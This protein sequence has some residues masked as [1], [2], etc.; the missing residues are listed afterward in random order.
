MSKRLQAVMSDDV[1]LESLTVEQLKSMLAE[2]NLP[3]TGKKAELIDRLNSAKQEN[4]IELSTSIW[5]RNVIGRF[6]LAQSVGSIAAVLLLMV[7]VLNPSILGFGEDEPVYQPI[8]FDADKTRW[9]AQELVN[10]GHPEWEGRM[11][12]SPEEAAAA[13]MI[14]D[15]LTE[16]GYS[17]QLNTYPVPM[18]AINSEPIVSMCIPPADGLFGAPVSGASCNSG[19]GAQVTSFNHRTDFVLQGYSGSADIQFGQEM[20]LIDL[21]DGTDDGLWGTA[22]GK[23][24]IVRGGNSIDGNTGIY[25]KAA[26][27]GLA[28]IFR[29]NNQS[30]CG[31]IENDDCVP[32][33]KSILVDDMKA[34]NSGS[35]PENIPF[36]A[37]SNNTG[38][39]MLEL[40]AQG[41]YLRLFSDVDNTGELSVSVPCGTLYG[42][43]DDL[44]IVGAHHDT[45]YHA[46]GAVD[47]TSGTATVLEMARQL[48]MIAN[49]SGTPDYTLRFCT[50][51]G[52]EEGLWGSKAYVGANANELAR[53]LRLYI[54]LDM[55]HVDVDIANRGNTL[56]FFSN[57]KEDINAMKDIVKV[58]EQERPDL[59]PKYAVTTGLLEGERG[60]PDGMPYNS[61][62]GPFVYDLP[63]GV[64]GNALVCYGTGSYE[65]HTYA[66]TMDRFNEESL[67]VSVIAYGTYIRHLAW[68]VTA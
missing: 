64:V 19:L 53:N 36:I 30:N 50:W 48:A 61:D 33:F 42:K 6:N 32:I 3:K 35:I 25:I 39:Q 5:S 16:M 15:N 18:F 2:K 22:A 27:N 54:N 49:E 63:D 57:S 4:V 59:F 37:V 28:G 46:Q 38:N 65:Y 47:D 12:G 67:G 11:S 52:E 41:A 9:Y 1:P 14:L 43:S 29:I 7:V 17:P 24:G 62:H 31:Q 20:E 56:R 58:L 10:L 45:V 55:N 34:A 21:D 40:A 26:E 8:G 60:A 51:G 44:I 23:V 66:D 68:P 13:Q